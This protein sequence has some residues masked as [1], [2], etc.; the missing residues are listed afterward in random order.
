MSRT[1]R[2]NRL[3]LALLIAGS[4]VVLDA[5]SSVHASAS[6]D[7]CALCA[8][9]VQSQGGTCS[10]DHFYPVERVVADHES[11]D[12]AVLEIGQPRL[13]PPS[14]GPPTAS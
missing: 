6:A 3:V 11:N 9:H 5:H 1:H 7:P 4:L 13:T 10:S 8:S 14:R 2:F 12:I